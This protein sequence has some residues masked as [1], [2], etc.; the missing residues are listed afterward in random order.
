M[1]SIDGASSVLASIIGSCLGCQGKLPYVQVQYCN[2]LYHFG[3]GRPGGIV[4]LWGNLGARY[5]LLVAKRPAGSPK[6]GKEIRWA[7]THTEQALCETCP[8]RYYLAARLQRAISLFKVSSPPRLAKREIKFLSTHTTNWITE[9]KSDS[10]GATIRQCELCLSRGNILTVTV[11][12]D[13]KRRKIVED[14]W[15]GP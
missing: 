4:E 5:W 12:G 7:G 2:K 10:E 1:K 8:Q 15:F 14:P 11:E 6:I 13:T 3:P 9:F